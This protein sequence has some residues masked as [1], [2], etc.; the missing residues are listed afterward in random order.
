MGHHHAIST[1]IQYKVN[2]A[3]YTFQ[4]CGYIILL[5]VGGAVVG[6]TFA[7]ASCLS[8]LKGFCYLGFF[9]VIF[10]VLERGEQDDVGFWY[11]SLAKCYFEHFRINRVD[12]KVSSAIRVYFQ[13]A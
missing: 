7:S 2:Y 9:L 11:K 3:I 4:D 13:G 1:D 12:T 6:G 8:S 5:F 10:L